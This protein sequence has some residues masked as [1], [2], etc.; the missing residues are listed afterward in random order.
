MASFLQLYGQEVNKRNVLS[1]AD[2]ARRFVTD[3]KHAG[4]FCTENAFT[5]RE[6]APNTI[7]SDGVVD[8]FFAKGGVLFF[9]T[10]RPTGKGKIYV[11]AVDF[12]DLKGSIGVSHGLQR[13]TFTNQGSIYD[14]SDPQ[15]IYESTFFGSNGFNGSPDYA[16]FGVN[17]LKQMHPEKFKWGSDSIADD[18][19][20]MVQIINEVS[21]GKMEIEVEC[22]NKR[23]AEVQGLNPETD[24]WPWFHINESMIGYAVQGPA[25]CEDYRQFAR[26]HQAAIC[27]AYRDIPGL[28]IE[29]IDFIYTIVPIN[30][31]GHRAGLQGGGGFDTSFSYNDQAFL[32]RESE[33]RHEPG[34]T[35]K[36]GRI[37]GSGVFGIKNLWPNGNPRNAVNISMHE[38]LHGMGMIDDYYYNW[39]PV[40]DNGKSVNAAINYRNTG[41]SSSGQKFGR[42]T[43]DLTAWKKFRT[44]WIGG[45]EVKVVLPGD[46]IILN[47][48]AL[49]SYPGAGGSYPHNGVSGDNPG[50]QTRMVL[51][52]KEWRTRDTFGKLWDNGWNPKK[53]DYNWYDWF[54]NPWVGGETRAI[55]SFPTFY[56]LEVRKPLGADNTMDANNQGVVISM[57]ANLTWETGN[58]AGGF[59]LCTGNSGLKEGAEWN[60]PNL[61]LTVTVL[62]SD[63]YFDKVKIKYTGKATPTVNP[64]FP[65]PAKHIYQGVLTATDNDVTAGETFTVDFNLFTLGVSA[66]NDIQSPATI[67]TAD[68]PY[69][70]GVVRVAT[71]LGVP[72]GIAGY[73]MEVQF[74]AGN[75]EYIS[76]GRVLG[77]DKGNYHINTDGV[78]DG[79]LVIS[80]SDNQMVDKDQIL[81]LNFRSKPTIKAGEYHIKATI[82]D[83]A[84][85]NW[86]GEKLNVG[87][88][89]F[90]GVG[91]ICNRGGI[92]ST[93]PLSDLYKSYMDEKIIRYHDYT[94]YVKGIF[95][96]GGLI[97]VGATTTFTLDGK[98]TCDT[99]GPAPGTFIGV[100]SKVKLFDSAGKLT[101]T[102]QSDWDG[103]Y[104]LQGI[105]AGTGYSITAEKPKYFKGESARFA[106]TGKETTAPGI[107]L[108]RLTF[109]V[110]GTICGGIGS[111]GLD[112]VPL[113]G[114][115]VY[116]VNIGNAYKILGGP[117]ITDAN[118]R[119]E[120]DAKV[121]TWNK[122]FAAV[123]VKT[124]EGYTPQVVTNSL[125]M[126]LGRLYGIDPNDK[127]YP[128]N[129]VNYGIGGGYN[130]LLD[131]DV[132]GRDI[133]L[134]QQQDVHIRVEPKS[135][136]TVYQLKKQDGTLVGAPLQSV[137]TTEGDDVMQNV[138]AG[139]PYLIEV[140]RAG[141]ATESTAPFFV[142]STRVFLRNAFKSN[143]LEL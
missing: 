6:F 123:A 141:Y 72:G 58:G 143:T 1:D 53:D 111:D 139:G 29:D 36:A 92:V 4:E 18:F 61:G 77:D 129:E 49:S 102:T 112:A 44:G 47:I 56:V 42:D 64:D 65:G 140:N 130:F 98:I 17:G 86:R 97:K 54:T 121:E 79:R 89:G 132:T 39:M 116:I 101:A 38:F 68:A 87:S 37:V 82:T 107:Q 122:P 60:D 106:V 75:F 142:S 51:I 119:Y 67:P 126:N 66:V 69:N 114:V 94:R 131:G 14:L 91:T 124:P 133:T 34:V 73:Q 78:T 8:P 85:L 31:F 26:L 46:E 52:P 63:S 70:N 93:D 127:I 71:P 80:A 81:S 48:K 83:V 3:D 105:P 15:V 134:T 128:A 21:L 113:S 84:L 27:A 59:K 45:D 99:P 115:E 55:K 16:Y 100:E 43:Q 108:Q 90:D 12:A 32:Q 120:I 30:A 88:P 50:V 33:F 103:N 2:I 20:G 138:P 57:L 23:L 104:A 95:S 13:N 118:G 125:S 109:K 11:I 135:K 7:M 117:C 9:P 22:L 5:L 40:D 28:D 96:R 41:E 110:S 74:D 35:T 19:K 62:E 76:A 137:G 136:E 24:K 25:D 10:D